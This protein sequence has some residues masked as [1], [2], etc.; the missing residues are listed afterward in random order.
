M[1]FPLRPSLSRA[2]LAG[3]LAL[4]PLPAAASE[5]APPRRP[6]GDTDVFVPVPS[7]R[8]VME[9]AFENFYHFDVHADLDFEVRSSGRVVLRYRTELLRKFID[10]RAHDLFYFEGDGDLRG[11]RVLR[12]ERDGRADD[13]FVYLPQLRRIRRH[14]MAQRADR[15]MAMDVTLEDLEVQRVDKFEIVGRAFAAVGGET[16]HLVTL[17]RLLESAYDRVDFFVAADDYAMLEVRF[18]RQGAREPYKVTHMDRAWMER[19]AG[20]VLPARI[21]FEDRDAGT[22]TTLWFRRREVDPELSSAP[23]STLS[24]EKRSRLSWIQHW[25]SEPGR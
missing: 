24:L 23:F 5:D 12:V 3:A 21:D 13:A 20:H 9:R 14:V 4:L 15:L 22:E 8:E 18:Y 6:G 25:G 1:S 7:A 11:R 19:H 16:A 10:G 2:L 17:K